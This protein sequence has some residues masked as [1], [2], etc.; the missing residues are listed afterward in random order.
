MK[1]VLLPILL[2]LFVPVVFAQSDGCDMSSFEKAS[3]TCGETKIINLETAGH[4][5]G[6]AAVN[7]QKVATAKAETELSKTNKATTAPDPF[8]SRLHNS[9]QDFLTPLSFA[10]NKVE[11]S[12]DGQSLIVRFNPLREEGLNLGLTGTITKPS[13]A[14]KVKEGIPE[15]KR[16]DIAEKMEKGLSDFEDVTAAVS[17]TY[18]RDCDIK[19]VERCFGRNPVTYRDLVS[20]VLVQPALIAN[21]ST[22]GAQTASKELRKVANGIFGENGVN[23]NFGEVTDP[24]KKLTIYQLALAAGK[25]DAADSIKYLETFERLGIDNLGTLIDNQPQL[26]VTGSYHRVGRFGGPDETAATLEYQ[27]GILNLRQIAKDCQGE[28]TQ[29]LAKTLADPKTSTSLS[30]KLVFSLSFKRADHFKLDALDTDLGVTDFTPVSIPRTSEWKGK[31]TWGRKLATKVTGEQPRIDIGGDFIR[32]SEAGARKVNRFVAR[33]T[34]TVPYGKNMSIP[35]S[36]AYANKADFLTDDRKKLSM[37][38]GISYR[39]PWEKQPE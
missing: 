38:F 6:V 29:C 31:A 34:L 18:T 12:K 33:A 23:K 22:G 35:V 30:D 39:F 8:A 25:A 19:H 32:Q 3:Q 24:I 14:A 2:F 9:Y 4:D 26:A 20:L 17:A 36:I 11:E 5:L 10:V 27:S 28:F 1:R 13:I 16:A 37:H 15:G 7:Q 21:A